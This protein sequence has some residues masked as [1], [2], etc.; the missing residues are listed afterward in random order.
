VVV[1][2]TGIS[3]GLDTTTWHTACNAGLLCRGGVIMSMVYRCILSMVEVI[4]SMQA[5]L[6]CTVSDP[7]GCSA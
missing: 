5:R 3:L 7:T 2:R 4:C 1:G 6:L